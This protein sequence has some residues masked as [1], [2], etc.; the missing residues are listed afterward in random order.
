ML[1][2]YV[3]PD[4]HIKLGFV[5]VGGQVVLF[6]VGGDYDNPVVMPEFSLMREGY[7]RFESPVNWD[8]TETDAQDIAEFA[9]RE[10]DSESEQV[11]Q[12][13]V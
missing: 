11:S 5:A 1:I 13:V 6:G 2:Q 7:I 8:G 9:V 12:F 3:L 10:L 4:L